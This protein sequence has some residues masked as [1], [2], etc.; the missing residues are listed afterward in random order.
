MSEV[1]PAGVQQQA[2][3]DRSEQAKSSRQE[4]DAR[5]DRQQEAPAHQLLFEQMR[6]Q[7]SSQVAQRGE[8][9]RGQNLQVEQEQGRGQA[10]DTV[11]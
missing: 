10:V 2:S 4:R 7:E 6:R 1:T 9:N 5:T 11:A 3:T 8:D